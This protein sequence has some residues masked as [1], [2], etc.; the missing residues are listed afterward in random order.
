MTFTRKLLSDRKGGLCCAAPRR[1]IT[2][3]A[4]YLAQPSSTLVFGVS[5]CKCNISLNTFKAIKVGLEIT[6]ARGHAYDRRKEV[7][8]VASRVA[9]PDHP[10]FTRLNWRRWPL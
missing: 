2:A 4:R 5:R 8:N 6:I 7:D 3:S 10:D 1:P 9:G